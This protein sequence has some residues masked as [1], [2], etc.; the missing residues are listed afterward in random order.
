MSDS[1]SIEHESSINELK[2]IKVDRTRKTHFFVG[3]SACFDSGHV[4]SFKHDACFAVWP[5]ET[6]AF[7]SARTS[8]I[9]LEKARVCGRNFVAHLAALIASSHP[10]F[11]R[12]YARLFHANACLGLVEIAFSKLAAAN[13][14]LAN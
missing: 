14:K 9:V 3:W 2:I 8:D 10:W 11:A 12:E 4:G 5:S 6:W 13:E 7:N 1:V